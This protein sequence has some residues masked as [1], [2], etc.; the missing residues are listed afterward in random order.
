MLIF[1]GAYIGLEDQNRFY[2]FETKTWTTNWGFPFPN[3]GPVFFN[4]TVIRYSGLLYT[5]FNPPE[6]VQHSIWSHSGDPEDDWQVEIELEKYN[7]RAILIPP[8]EA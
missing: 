8:N 1:G 7:G 4:P 5:T 6:A 3:D 2:D